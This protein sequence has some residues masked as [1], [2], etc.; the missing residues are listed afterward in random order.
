MGEVLKAGEPLDLETVRFSKTTNMYNGY[1]SR[2][3]ETQT[4]LTSPPK[5]NPP[6][7]VL[8]KLT[9]CSSGACERW[10][11]DMPRCPFSL[12]LSGE[13]CS[14]N[15]G[16]CVV[17]WDISKPDLATGDLLDFISPV[18][19]GAYITHDFYMVEMEQ[20]VYQV[21]VN[22]LPSANEDGRFFWAYHNGEFVYGI[23]LVNHLLEVEE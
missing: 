23:Y 2:D 7:E 18:E 5:V 8:D 12:F 22:W 14:P 13:G 9:E 3:L 21:V 6:E 20:G 16:L 19:K 11:Y 17:R 10:E 15:T 1:R 4:S